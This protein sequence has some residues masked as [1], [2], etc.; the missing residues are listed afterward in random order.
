[1]TDWALHETLTE[2]VK[3]ARA[4]LSIFKPKLQRNLD[5]R[6]NYFQIIKLIVRKN[7]YRVLCVSGTLVFKRYFLTVFIVY[8]CCLLWFLFMFS[9][10]RIEPKN[11]LRYP[12]TGESWVQRVRVVFP[13]GSREC[14]WVAQPH[15]LRPWGETTPAAVHSLA[16]H[17]MT[18]CPTN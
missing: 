4:S 17:A 1:M 11:I 7:H 9:D 14:G 3:S 13:V 15:I 6:W 5:I 18:S 16:P 2:L 10:C 8:L 12:E